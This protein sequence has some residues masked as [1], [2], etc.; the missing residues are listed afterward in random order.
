MSFNPICK[1]PIATNHNAL[2]P[3]NNSTMT[4]EEKPDVS[5]ADIGG[6]KEQLDKI[7]EVVEMP[8][9]YET[10]NGHRASSV[11]GRIC[12]PPHKARQPTLHRSPVPATHRRGYWHVATP[13]A[14]RRTVQR[15]RAG[16]TFFKPKLYPTI[17]QHS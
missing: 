9:L 2:S 7:R 8:L 12:Q 13:N 10:D 6:A 1:L 14:I 16:E 17:A 5:Y 15:V 4:V 3:N 11:H